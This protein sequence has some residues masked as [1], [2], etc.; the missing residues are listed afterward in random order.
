MSKYE[1]TKLCEAHG[2]Q[3]AETVAVYIA[4]VSPELVARWLSGVKN[5]T[6]ID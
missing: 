5:I 1:F 3:H 4:H 2:T 6:L